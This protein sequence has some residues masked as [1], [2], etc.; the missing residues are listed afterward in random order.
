MEKL[1]KPFLPLFSHLAF[2]RLD[3]RA[4]LVHKHTNNS[5]QLQPKRMARFS[6][7]L[8]LVA[9]M[10]LAFDAASSASAAP[11]ARDATSATRLERRRRALLE[12]EPEIV[13]VAGA[14]GEA[15]RGVGEAYLGGSGGSVGEA[16][17]RRSSNRR[18][19]L[20][21]IV[22]EAGEAFG[23]AYGGVPGRR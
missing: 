16:M 3:L 10:L 11:L 13:N 15:Y 20:R 12:A 6:A 2:I 19:K 14:I 17:R 4:S 7:L 23:E 8:A 21:G 5:F 22:G 1:A 9:G 18:R